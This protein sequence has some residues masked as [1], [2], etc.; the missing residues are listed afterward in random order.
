M[1]G[2]LVVTAINAVAFLLSQFQSPTFVQNGPAG[3]FPTCSLTGRLS[4]KNSVQT[5][6]ICLRDT[7]TDLSSVAF[8]SFFIP[9]LASDAFLDL[10]NLA[11]WTTWTKTS[12]KSFQIMPFFI[13]SDT[14]T[15]HSSPGKVLKGSRCS[16]PYLEKT[17]TLSGMCGQ[18]GIYR[19]IGLSIAHL[20]VNRPVYRLKIILTSLYSLWCNMNVVLSLPLSLIS[21]CQYQD[22]GCFV[23]HRNVSPKNSNY[24]S[25]T[26]MA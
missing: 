12:I 13:S 22:L 1:I 5:I 24:S 17:T 3:T 11:G 18:T 21:I 10:Q 4:P 16:S 20:N 9:W 7:E 25:I 19:L 23:K 26:W 8:L 14:S 2:F 6:K 15:L